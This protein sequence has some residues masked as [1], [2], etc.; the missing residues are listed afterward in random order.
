MNYQCMISIS[1]QLRE[2]RKSKKLTVKKLSELSLVCE[3][4]IYR[5]EQERNQHTY[6]YTL[7]Q[8]QK[9]LNIKFEI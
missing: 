6:V 3:D 5:I 8:L 1:I 7:Q 2:A 9:V 4:T